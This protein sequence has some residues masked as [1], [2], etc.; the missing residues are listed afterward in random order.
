[1]L[2]PKRTSFPAPKNRGLHFY[3]QTSLYYLFLQPPG[4]R[5]RAIGYEY[6]Q[7][8]MEVALAWR[9]VNGLFWPRVVL[10]PS[11]FEILLRLSFA[12]YFYYSSTTHTP[13]LPRGPLSSFLR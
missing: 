13:N 10:C 8:L 12:L 5:Y 6:I 4:L 2:V 3:T 11:R 9:L 7:D 1:M